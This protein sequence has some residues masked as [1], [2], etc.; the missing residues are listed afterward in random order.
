MTTLNGNWQAIASHAT[1]FVGMHTAVIY[2]RID[3]QSQ[4]ANKSAVLTKLE[5]QG[6]SY[7]HDQVTSF[8]LTGS[9]GWSGDWS[10]S[11]TSTVASGGW[12][13]SHDSN[14]YCS[15]YIGACA[16]FG[17]TG[18]GTGQFGATVD[19]PRITPKESAKTY[20]PATPSINTYPNNSPNVTA[21]NTITIH[22]N[23]TD[24]AER[25]TLRY[26]FGSLSGT[27]GSNIH[28]NTTFN[29][30]TNWCAQFKTST[31]GSGTIYCDT[32]VNGSL[33][34]T[35]SCQIIV[36]VPSGAEPGISIS[37]IEEQNSN[38][39]SI[40]STETIQSLSSKKVTVTISTKYDSYVSGVWCNGVQ[41]SG[42]GSAYSGTLSNMQTGTYSVSVKDSRGYTSSTSSKQDFY[43]YNKPSIKGSASRTSQTSA[44]GSLTVTGT[45]SQIKSNTATVTITRVS[46]SSTTTQ[47]YTGGSSFTKTVSYTDLSYTTEFTWTLTVK[48]R[49]NQTDSVSYKL[50]MGQYALWLGR[51]HIITPRIKTNVIEGVQHRAN[52][53]TGWGNIFNL[54]IQNAW[55]SGSYK[56]DITGYSIG[57]AMTLYIRNG[58]RSTADWGGASMAIDCHTD[59]RK[60]IKLAFDGNIARVWMHEYWTKG[61]SVLHTCTGYMQITEGDKE[62]QAAEPSGNYLW[63]SVLWTTYPVGSVWI[64]YTGSKNP[65]DMWGGSW[66]RLTDNSTILA[67]GSA[68]SYGGENSHTLSWAEMPTHY[69]GQN[70]H[71]HSMGRSNQGGGRTDWG[72]TGAGAHGGNVVLLNG[73]GSSTTGDAAPNTHNAGSG[74]AHNNMMYYRNY[75]VWLRTA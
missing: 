13:Q 2:A 69:H 1:G 43:Y 54:V 56:I 19:L 61:T 37:S 25:F 27:I 23:N 18:K 6:S 24:D 75:G 62:S 51:S 67:S 28:Y 49:F 36:S 47:T 31:S 60:K 10:A 44:T 30:P 42:S 12:E 21:G 53:G 66:T 20:T 7:S 26:T 16:T 52:S 58:N 11:S 22:T 72:L 33:I 9:G 68:N 64:D 63:S 45:Y 59:D 5:I 14:G 35:R 73:N 48:D 32:Y 4:D 39:K 55:D 46:P 38:V 40:T 8:T 41:L 50:G 70:S 57:M 17:G 15:V 74:S 34:G 29:V 3:W 65:N 71:N